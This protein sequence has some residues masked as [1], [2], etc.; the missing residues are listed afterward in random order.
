MNTY[1]VLEDLRRRYKSEYKSN[2]DTG[3]CQILTAALVCRRLIHLL[4]LKH[5]QLIVTD[6]AGLLEENLSDVLVKTK[7]THVRLDRKDV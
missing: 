7:L 1:H 3:K 2:V 6:C 5:L 4:V